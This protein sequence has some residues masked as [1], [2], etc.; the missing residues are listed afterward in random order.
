M[1]IGGTRRVYV[2]NGFGDIVLYTAAAGSASPLTAVGVLLANSNSGDFQYLHPS[3]DLVRLS[4]GNF[5]YFYT[6]SDQSSHE[7]GS[8]GVLL[9]NAA[10]DGFT[11]H[12]DDFV[13]ISDPD[14]VAAGLTQLDGMT[15]NN[16]QF[17]DNTMIFLLILAGESVAN[18]S[19]ADVFYAVGTISFDQTME[20]A[21]VDSDEDDVTDCFD[22]DDQNPDVY[23][24]APQVCD[25]VNNDCD[26]PNWPAPDNTNEGDDD[27][28]LFTECAGDCDDQQPSIYPGAPE[29]CDGLNNDCDHPNWPTPFPIEV[30]QDGDAIAECAGDCDES[31]SSVYPGAEQVCDGLNNDCDHPNWPALDNTTE[32]D[33]DVDSYTEC[34][35]DCDDTRDDVYPAAQQ[36]CDGINNDCDHPDW[37]TV[38]Y[39][40]IDN[41]GDTI[42]ECQGDCD[43][44]SSTTYPGA[45]QLCDGINNDCDQQGW[46]AVP[47]DELDND[48]DNITVCQG[49]CDD[50]ART[51]YPGALQLCDGVNNDCDDASWPEVP[52]EEA[53]GDQ[54]E[55]RLCENDCDDTNPEV[56][57]D[58]E[59]ICNA[60]DDDCNDLID[61]DAQGEDTDTDG[62]HNLCDNCPEVI[63][64]AQ[65]DT[66]GDLLGN[67]CDN[68][69]FVV[70]PDQDDADLDDRGDLCEN[71]LENYNP[72]Q[73]DFEGDGVGDVCDNCY[74]LSNPS[75][76]DF[77]D[78][79]EGDH[80]DLDDGLI[81]IVFRHRNKASWQEEVGYFSWNAYRGDLSVL[82]STGV[83]TQVPGSN[84][85]AGRECGL[86]D[87]IW[88]GIGT[89]DPG[90][91]A[92][93]LATG[94]NVQGE[95]DLGTDSAGNPRPNTYPCP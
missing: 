32:S 71:C 10:G 48:G 67:S 84:D 14:L 90:E 56:N 20:C 23:P 81:Y 70:N 85:L 36:V 52:A 19:K 17:I 93:F 46:P 64:P 72:Y 22:C 92:F 65:A 77:D 60:L 18:E 50:A 49:D 12:E 55:Y 29:L 31:D 91:T 28:D 34:L 4:T 89:P 75:Q 53:D 6:E 41:D 7:H 57:P 69:I 30:D 40:E 95:S 9:L 63:N 45:E 68:C 66:D 21:T 26:H 61:E 76:S 87:P 58:A 37:P 3:G 59:E 13:T 83:Y 82:F 39:D 88:P 35:G 73:D 11:D 94:V 1:E 42:A 74:D 33:D 62:V 15:V 25:G 47:L 38:P 86:M 80:C 78:D 24:N 51:V 8:V 16:I 54:D 79:F 5:L 44:A 2:S 43:D 27:A